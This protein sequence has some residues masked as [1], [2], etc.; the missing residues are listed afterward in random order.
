MVEERKKKEFASANNKPLANSNSHAAISSQ[1][2]SMG[3]QS[4]RKS[5][6]TCEA[7]I[8]QHLESIELRLNK[9]KKRGQRYMEGVAKTSA[10]IGKSVGTP[11]VPS[12]LN[13]G[14]LIRPADYAREQQVLNDLSK[15][16][17]IKERIES[18]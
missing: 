18:F 12:I 5:T 8:D 6:E 1:A 3:G 14:V 11:C 16:F 7:N 13:E 2:M 10:G 4:K 9:G 17:A 15:Q